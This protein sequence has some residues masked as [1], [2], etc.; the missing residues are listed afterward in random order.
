MTRIIAGFAGSRELK[1]PKQGTRPTS[2]RVREALFSALE[3]ADLIRGSRV[4]DLYAGTGALG[5]EALSRGAKHV[6]LVENNL[7]AFKI[8]KANA[9]LV[10]NSGRRESGSYEVR[11][12]SVGRFLAGSRDVWNL[13]L[14]DPPYTVTNDE[15]E[16]VLATLAREM[17]RDGVVVVERSTRTPVFKAPERMTIIRTQE[18]GDT[19]LIWLEIVDY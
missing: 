13:V 4:L 5:L 16:L 15:L 12:E 14:I 17:T 11:G 19:S 7:K 2:D 3:S 10:A 9:R 18:Y 1:V 6:A 8:I